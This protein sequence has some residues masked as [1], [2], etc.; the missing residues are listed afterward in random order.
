VGRAALSFCGARLLTGAAALKVRPLNIRLTQA[1]LRELHEGVGAPD[2]DRDDVATGIVHFG[3]GAFFRAHTAWY[4]DR[5]LARDSR[6]GICAVSLKTG[7]LARA[8]AEQDFL[9]ALA[10]LDAA[11]SYRVIGSLKDYVVAS[12]NPARV[13]HRLTE[14]AVKLVTITVTEKGYCLDGAGALDLSHP[15]IVHDLGKPEAPRSLIGWIAEGLRRRRAAGLSAFTVLSCDN[16]VANGPKLRAAVLGFVQRQ[17]NAA[18]ADWIEHDVRFPATMVDS[19]TPHADE[20]FLKT[21]AETTGLRDEAAVRRERFAQWVIED[22]VPAD[23]PDLASVGV[24]MTKSVKDYE[25]AK[26]RLL[27]GAHSALAYLGI[28]AGHATVFEAMSD[29]ALAHFVES[30]MR[31]DTART[32]HVGFD[33]PAY[34]DRL[35]VRLKNPAV[36]H[37]LMQIA[38]DGSIKIPYRF[39]EPAAELLAANGDPGRLLVPVAAWMRFVVTEIRAG[40]TLDDPL[41][42]RLAEI[43]KTAQGV[44]ADVDLFLLLDGVFP[45]ALK[46]NPRFVK[47]LTDAY[48]NLWATA[49]HSA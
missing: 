17:G 47:A 42:T 37:R 22:D 20:A 35:I 49:T 9:Y 18:L 6:W 29:A 40:R 11:P 31:E 2:Y 12:E 32:L 14:P 13:F 30:M 33:I 27:N 45:S 26:L 44:A 4:V 1:S 39:L 34:I 38:A 48:A 46:E 43:G 7:G 36:A 41:A 8:L 19:I 5:L 15:D 25:R 3:P 24:T 10:E 23:F 28:A 21:I 16:L